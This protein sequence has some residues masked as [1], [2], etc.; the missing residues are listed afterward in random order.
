[1]YDCDKKSMNASEFRKQCFALLDKLP[2]E[3]IVIT[4]RGKAIARI[5]PVRKNNADSIGSMA[6]MFEIK[7]DIF[8]AGEKWDAES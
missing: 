4:R 6:G 7:G 8:S 5:T 1:M 2:P 3:G